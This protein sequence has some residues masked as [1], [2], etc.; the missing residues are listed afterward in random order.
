MIGSDSGAI[1]E[2]IGDAG[3]VVPEGNAEALARALRDLYG[4]PPRC[5]QLARAGRDRVLR[6]FT[7][8]RVA[9]MCKAIY[10]GMLDGTLDTEEVAP[11]ST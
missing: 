6:Y 2:V 7:W 3:I 10:D 1:P 5:A 11:W 9:E 8:Q 4:D